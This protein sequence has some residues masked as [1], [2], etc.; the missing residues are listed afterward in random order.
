MSA[1]DDPDVHLRQAGAHVDR[2]EEPDGEV[3]GS[4]FWALEIGGRGGGFLM[5]GCFEVEAWR[6]GKWLG[7]CW[8]QADGGGGNLT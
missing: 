4:G 2:E 3:L 1:D 6:L 7:W 8:I 5:V